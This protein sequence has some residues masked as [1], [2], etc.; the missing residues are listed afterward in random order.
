MNLSTA[1]HALVRG[2]IDLFHQGN[3]NTKNVA[4]RDRLDAMFKPHMIAMTLTTKQI[5]IHPRNRNQDAFTVDGVYVRG[6]RVL[7]SGFSH[8]SIGEIWCFEDHPVKKHIEAHTMAVLSSESRFATLQK[9]QIRVAP[10]N[11][12]HTNQF[13]S[14]VKDEALCD[15]PN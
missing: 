6:E 7:N 15:N 11:W 10:A 13:M 2:Q 14:M 5:G 12:T 4:I 3:D 9:G 1:E 8:N